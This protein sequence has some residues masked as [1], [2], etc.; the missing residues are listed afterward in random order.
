MNKNFTFFVV[1]FLALFLTASG[2]FVQLQAEEINLKEYQ[3]EEIVVTAEKKSADIQEVPMSISAFSE[4]NLNDSGIDELPE[5]ARFSPNVYMKRNSIVIRGITQYYGSKSSTVGIYQDDVSLP[6]DGV[7]NFELFDIERIEILKGPQGVL[8]G[9]NSEAGVVNI[10]T[11]QPGNEVSGKIYTEYSWYD[12]EFGNAPNYIVGTSLSSPIIKDKL[13]FRL[14]GKWTD[15]A[16]YMKNEYNGDE[17]VGKNDTFNGRI[18]LRW[19]PQD[20]WDIAFLADAMQSD[21]G[22][23]YFR[24][25]TGTL[26]EGRHRI[27]Y[28]GPCTGDRDGN[29][30]TLRVKYSGDKV[31]VLSITGRRHYK[32][33]MDYDFDMTSLYSMTTKTVDESTSLSQEIRISSVESNEP[34]QWLTGVYFFD[35]DIQIY[36][37]KISQTT[38]IR[39]TD[40][41]SFGYAFFGQGTYTFIDRLHLTAGLRYDF[42]DF[43]GEQELT[44]GGALTVYGNEFDNSELLPKASVSFDFSDDLMAY[45]SVTRGYLT[46]GYNFKWATNVNNLTYDPEYTWNYEIGIK[47]SWFDNRVIANI[48]AFYIEMKDKQVAEWDTTS[49]SVSV[50]TISNASNAYSRGLELTLQAR[51]PVQGVDIF[52]GFGVIEA[53]INDWI[54]TEYD[55][56]TGS[57]YQYDYSDNRLPNVPNYTYNLGVQ[58]RHISGFFCRADWFGTGSV[59]SDSKNTAKEDGY[60]IFNLRLG[61]ESENYDIHLWCKN[62]FDEEY[63]QVRFASSGDHQG[64]DGDPRI[65]GIT[66]TYRF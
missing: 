20:R 47:S 55:S 39:D 38:T 44:N 29:G 63:L 5:I 21:Y 24:Y 26:N 36:Q 3:I 60:Q 57:S 27:S 28:N 6:F 11:K 1:S 8:Y 64:L 45:A 37:D 41:D 46:G 25:I 65:M 40:V 12:T 16:G 56:T 22:Y 50:Q 10:I 62:L 7:D 43:K 48:S 54:S 49:G 2:S 59:Y 13:Y 52:A 61:F 4:M 53:K 30:Q 15:D 42:T 66:F 31:N 32:D 14:S 51:P 17:D 18:N 33:D 23:G 58:Y 9:K 35:E 34:F 19:T